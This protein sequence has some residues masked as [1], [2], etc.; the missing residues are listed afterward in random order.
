MKRYFYAEYNRFGLRLDYSSIGWKVLRFGSKAERESFLDENKWN[1]CNQVVAT[2]K[3]K[4][5]GKVVRLKKG[6]RI[7]W[8]DLGMGVEEACNVW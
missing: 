1:G 6:Q 5:I 4:N 7:E 8:L 2:I 3:A